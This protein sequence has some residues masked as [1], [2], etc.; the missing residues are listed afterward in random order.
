LL[1]IGGFWLDIV[2]IVDSVG[3]RVCQTMLVV[4]LA[5]FEICR[6]LF[7]IDLV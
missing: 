3:L 6:A 4:D 7:I 5:G 1:S 2:L